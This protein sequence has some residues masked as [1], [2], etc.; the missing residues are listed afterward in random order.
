MRLLSSIL[1]KTVALVFPNTCLI[2]NKISPLKHF[3]KN[4]LPPPELISL[5]TCD[6]CG[7]PV[8]LCACKWN[9]YYFDKMISCLEADNKTKSAFYSFKFGGNRSGYEFFS[10]KM[11]E[12]LNEKYG[13]LKIDIITS[14]PSHKSTLN[15]RGYDQ[16]K[17]L[18]KGIS[19]QLK[20]K[21]IPLLKQP[22][23]ASKQHET[24]TIEQRFSNVVSK[25]SFCNNCNIKG[26]TILLVDDIKTTGATL[27][28]CAKEL[29][30]S[31]AESVFAIT[32]LTVYPKN[33]DEEKQTVEKN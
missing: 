6:K 3:C 31:G 2:C 23:K 1:E 19:R 10:E 24:N 32:A 13:D 16:V 33:K 14:V 27:S 9:F 15:E 28:Q 20:V 11:V 29:K 21:Y 12:R 18:A 26:K 7:L 8:K 30:L 25:Y 17:L 5:K 4:C 22:K